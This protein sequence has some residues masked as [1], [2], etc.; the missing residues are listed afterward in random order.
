MLYAHA[1]SVVLG[2]EGCGGGVLLECAS[3]LSIVSFFFCKSRHA[4]HSF[5][6]LVVRKTTSNR[7]WMEHRHFFFSIWPLCS[8]RRYAVCVYTACMCRCFR[9]RIHLCA[10]SVFSFYDCLRP[11]HVSLPSLRFVLTHT[12]TVHTHTRASIVHKQCARTH[13]AAAAQALTPTLPWPI[14]LKSHDRALVFNWIMR[15][16]RETCFCPIDM[17]S[18]CAALNDDHCDN[19]FSKITTSFTYLA[20]AL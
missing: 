2:G 4:A 19:K 16:M 1:Y 11:Y 20:C 8:N 17:H 9:M 15:M 5:H 12:S 13:T 7:F 10:S 14:S 18:D 6:V 3:T